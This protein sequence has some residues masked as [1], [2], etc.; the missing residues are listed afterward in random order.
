[1]NTASQPD[2]QYTCDDCR[3]TFPADERARVTLCSKHAATDRLAS[4]LREVRYAIQ[5]ALDTDTGA[6]WLHVGITTTAADALL[7][8]IEAQP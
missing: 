1:M 4:A 3:V 2:T 6:D 5:Q 8:E 7:D